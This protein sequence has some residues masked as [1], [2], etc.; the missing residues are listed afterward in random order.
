MPVMYSLYSPDIQNN[1][2]NFTVRE[3]LAALLLFTLGSTFAVQ[4][5]E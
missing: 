3:S 1:I 5:A 2:R 4:A